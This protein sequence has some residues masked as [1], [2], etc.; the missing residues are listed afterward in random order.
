MI[1]QVTMNGSRNGTGNEDLKH[2]ITRI[3]TLMRT[4]RESMRE[5]GLEKSVQQA[6]ASIPDGKDR[7]RYIAQMTAQAAEKTL[8]GIDVIKP[9][10]VDM[11][12][13]AIALQQQWEEAASGEVSSELRESTQA[14]LGQVI[15]DSEVTKAELLEIMMAQD[16][17]DLTGQVVKKMMEVVEEAEKQLLALLMEN[18]PPEMRV[19][20]QS[21]SLLNG[22]QINKE[23]VNVMASQ[24]QV[25]DLLDELGF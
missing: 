5:L 17:Q 23:G 16:F 19:K 6:V 1:E 25:D 14:F 8:N 21:E 2:V 22:P 18:T 13:N 15:Q 9:L 12:K 20:T 24:S 4:L 3:G 10:Q 11:N 7:L